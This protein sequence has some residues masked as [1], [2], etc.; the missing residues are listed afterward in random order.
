MHAFDDKF[1]LQMDSLLIEA[2][3]KDISSLR[4]KY[5]EQNFIIDQIEAR[6]RHK[7][8]LPDFLA[9]PHFLFPTLL[10][11]EQATNQWVA[12]FNASFVADNSSVADLT[13]GLGIDAMSMAEKCKCVTAFDIDEIKT[14]VLSHNLNV[15]EI[16]NTT[17]ICADSI[18]WLEE[19]DN[20]YDIIFIDP[21]RRSKSGNRV[22]YF[23][24]CQPDIVAAW[25]LLLSR[26]DKI[27][28][29]ASPMIDISDTLRRLSEVD[30][31]YVVCFK[32]ECKEVLILA[33]KWNLHKIAAVDIDKEH[34]K[35]EFE[36][37]LSD[38]AIG[39]NIDYVSSA[40]ELEGNYL[41]I[42]DAGVMKLA[43][44]S[45]LMRKYDGLKKLDPST[46][47]FASVHLYQDFPGKV[48]KVMEKPDKKQM[49]RLQN[50][51]LH[52]I[53]RNY[54]MGAAEIEKKYR[55]IPRGNKYLIACKINGKPMM[56]LS[57]II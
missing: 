53:S 16:N 55:A 57:E 46:H 45:A 19:H 44:W 20:H 33:G 12:K 23:E 2:E 29:K 17:V 22:S 50:T 41:Y 1:F 26:A 3:G 34:V 54:P 52:V 47:V 18:K 14:K 49:K 21:A 30:S 39:G 7:D 31:V 5:P 42:P 25:P 27:M 36:I 9:N 48:Y 4:L 15:L 32:G 35:S 51:D 8:K 13:C 10:S 37:P 6:R 40:M 38:F 11:A 24:D 43:E 56:I 28:I